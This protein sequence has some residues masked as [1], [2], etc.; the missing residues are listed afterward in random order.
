[1]VFTFDI[2]RLGRNDRS[3]F[4]A[5]ISN[6][7]ISFSIFI[8]NSVPSGIKTSFP[9][10]KNATIGASKRSAVCKSAPVKK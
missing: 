6:T 8:S 4:Y 9:G 7:G 1:M 2:L 5:Y 10:I 3:F